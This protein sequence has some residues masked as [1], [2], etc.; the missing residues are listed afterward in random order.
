MR[1]R[2]I[3]GMLAAMLLVGL[4]APAAYADATG[5]AAFLGTAAVGD[6]FAPDCTKTA[7][8]PVGKG[9]GSDPLAQKNNTW[10]LDAPFD[11]IGTS[12]SDPDG[13]DLYSGIF[14]VCGWMTAPLNLK[15][16]LGATCGST[17]G[18]HGRG[19][20]FATAGS[21]VL[22]L[23]LYDIGWKL[24]V[25]PILPVTGSYQEY[26]PT[27]V[28]KPKFGNIVAL[29]GAAPTDDNPTGCLDNTQTT[30]SIAGVAALVNG[31]H[32][33]GGNPDKGK[34]DT[35][36]CSGEPGEICPAPGPG[37]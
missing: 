28:K 6:D 32:F 14:H 36:K 17:K 22:S 29:V 16:P 5:V 12:W 1:S 25:G 37:K 19:N 26:A 21:K 23:K 34:Y 2:L 10:T 4:L 33:P 11:Y 35:K 3:G 7:G 18:M 27:G 13:I 20:A 30:F 9:L 24:A 31:A 15:P 8:T